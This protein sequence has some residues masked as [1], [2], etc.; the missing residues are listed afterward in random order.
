MALENSRLV[1]VK[2][3]RRAIVG[4][5]RMRHVHTRESQQRQFPTCLRLSFVA[6]VYLT[7]ISRKSPTA[8]RRPE[9][10][11]VEYHYRLHSVLLN[12]FMDNFAIEVNG[13]SFHFAAIEL[14]NSVPLNDT[15]MPAVLMRD[16]LQWKRP[17]LNMSY[18]Q[19]SFL[20]LI[21]V[22]PIK[23]IL[24]LAIK[25][26]EGLT[27]YGT[28]RKNFKKITSPWLLFLSLPSIPS[29]VGRGRG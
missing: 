24:I 18:L 5:G 21:S 9:D 29:S 2:L 13:A 28:P 10:E 11:G 23:S 22:I 19:G 1:I 6:P 15:I 7:S 14:G 8:N 17:T 3:G 16:R 25:S 12:D 27:L 20:R 26:S 4:H